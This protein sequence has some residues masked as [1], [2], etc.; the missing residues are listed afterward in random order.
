[1]INLLRADLYKLFHT[2]VLYVCTIVLVIIVGIV[3]AA[4]YSLDHS[5]ELR[6]EMMESDA[7]NAEKDTQ[8]NNVQVVENTEDQAD[9]IQIKVDPTVETGE[10]F[11]QSGF[12]FASGLMGESGFMV[13]MI[14]ILIAI[15]VG[16]EFKERTI[17]SM[18]SRGYKREAIVVT[19][20]IVSSIA[21]TIMLLVAE[22]FAFILGTIISGKFNNLSGSDLTGAWNVILGSLLGYLAF[23]VLFVMI[24]MVLR[25]VEMSVVLNLI[26]ICLIPDILS[27]MERTWDIPFSKIQITDA[28]VRVID[29]NDM[30]HMV[31]IFIGYLLV[32]T[33]IGC[34]VFK[35]ADV[36]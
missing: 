9:G 14:G 25:N 17:K 28:I 3:G 20:V 13:T 26:L 10:E 15:L 8:Q 27:T 36:K 24:V 35:R 12:Q 30:G 11:L 18:V 23:T 1:M 34:F 29:H 5:P 6:K 32:C 7:D 2:K 31:I 33:T 21:A 4:F 22:I 16:S 19:K